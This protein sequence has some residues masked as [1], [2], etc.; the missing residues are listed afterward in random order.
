MYRHRSLLNLPQKMIVFIVYFRSTM[1][2]LLQGYRQ[3]KQQQDRG[4]LVCLECLYAGFQESIWSLWAVGDSVTVTT[5]VG[6]GEFLFLA[7]EVIVRNRS[8]W[9]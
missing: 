9:A 1:K 2:L 8:V 3:P 7:I 5:V 6:H 4:A